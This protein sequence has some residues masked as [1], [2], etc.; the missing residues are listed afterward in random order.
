MQEDSPKRQSIHMSDTPRGSWASS[1]FDLKNSQADPLL[2]N[3][4]DRIDPEEI[5]RMNDKQRELQRQDALFSLFPK[6]DEV[7]TCLL[8]LRWNSVIIYSCVYLLID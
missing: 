4:L 7:R 1:I 3:L 2:P 6:Q 5:D 8:V